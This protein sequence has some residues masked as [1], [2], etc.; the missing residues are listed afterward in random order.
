MAKSHTK[1]GNAAGGPLRTTPGRSDP[2]PKTQTPGTATP[3]EKRGHDIVP[4]PTGA[5]KGGRGA[6]SWTGGKRGGQE[7][8]RRK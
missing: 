7:G 8:P 4:P 2:S 3:T 5:E 6:P 1:T